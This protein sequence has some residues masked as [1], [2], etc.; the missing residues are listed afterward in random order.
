VSTD[1]AAASNVRSAPPPNRN[2][3]ISGVNALSVTRE[4]RTLRLQE[5]SSAA[6]SPRHLPRAR[7]ATPVVTP[8]VYASAHPSPPTESRQSFQPPPATAGPAELSQLPN[9]TPSPRS[10]EP[11][12]PPKVVDDDSEDDCVI[13]DF[14]RPPATS[15]FSEHKRKRLTNGTTSFYARPSSTFT[16]V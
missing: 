8:P 15:P 9:Q 1:T 12:C 13:I 16:F 14:I 6:S 3:Q 4:Q 2:E 11:R 7:T 5:P 10:P